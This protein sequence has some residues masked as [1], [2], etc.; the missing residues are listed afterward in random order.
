MLHNVNQ[1]VFGGGGDGGKFLSFRFLLSFEGAFREDLPFPFPFPLTID[2]GSKS[3]SR[4]RSDF[5]CFF[6]ISGAGGIPEPEVDGFG[7][8]GFSAGDSM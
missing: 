1:L 3:G 2:L 7:E 8:T 6:M 5:F 4:S